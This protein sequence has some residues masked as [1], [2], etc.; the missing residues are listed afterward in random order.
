[1]I[2]RINLLTLFFFNPQLSLLSSN[3]L[4]V[5]AMAERSTLIHEVHLEK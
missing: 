2:Q 4:Y 5:L 1:M 3:L